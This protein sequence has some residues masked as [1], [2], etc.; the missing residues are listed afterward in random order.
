MNT[1]LCDWQNRNRLSDQGMADYVGVPLHTWQNWKRGKRQL[2]SAPRRL[3][4]VMQAVETFAP[5]IV[6]LIDGSAA[7]VRSR[8][9]GAS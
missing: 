9:G 8:K 3:I 2:D 7:M 1:E 6:S 5:G 4:E